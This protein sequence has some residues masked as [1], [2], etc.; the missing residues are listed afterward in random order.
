MLI[1][2]SLQLDM[3]RVYQSSCPVHGVILSKVKGYASTE[4]LSDSDL[5][6][7]S[8]HLYRRVWDPADIVYPV[9]GGEGETG[10]FSIVTNLVITQNQSLGSCGEELRSFSQC[11]NDSDCQEGYSSPATHG[12]FTGKCFDATGTCEI[13]AWCPI[14]PRTLARSGHLPLLEDVANF[15]VMLKNTVEF[16]GCGLGKQQGRNLPSDFRQADYLKKCKYDENMDPLCPIFKIGDI[17]SSAGGNFTKVA[18]MGGVFRIK[19]VWNCDFDF[20]RGVDDCLPRYEFNRVDDREANVSKGWNFRSARF[21]RGNHRTLKKQFGLK[22]LITLE[23]EGRK[24]NFFQLVI[25]LGATIGLFSVVKLLSSFLSLNFSFQQED[26][27]V[28]N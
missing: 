23:G 10:S 20:G 22:I 13:R 1:F 2:F 27:V 5:S 3:R 12:V 11:S 4:N 8:P 18:V 9:H 26:F 15:T 24:F 7:E 6:I 25:T 16:P 28:H 14:E 19:V 17:V 21:Y